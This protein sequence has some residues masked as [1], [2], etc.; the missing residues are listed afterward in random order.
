MAFDGEMRGVNPYVQ[1]GVSNA[2]SL[3]DLLVYPFVVEPLL[4]NTTQASVW[5]SRYIVYGVIVLFSL[6]RFMQPNG[7]LETPPINGTIF[8]SI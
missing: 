2:G 7:S 6:V 1:Y 5:S 8:K 3:L 4:D